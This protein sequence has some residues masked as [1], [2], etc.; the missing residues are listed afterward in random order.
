MRL[1]RIDWTKY[2]SHLPTGINTKPHNKNSAST[3]VKVKC[4]ID[5]KL[6]TRPI[7]LQEAIVL[8]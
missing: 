8:N 2:S 3:F 1:P 5:H 6:P 7:I 4:I